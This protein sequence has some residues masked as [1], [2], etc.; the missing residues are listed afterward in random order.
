MK[1]GIAA[2]TAPNHSIRSQDERN[3]TMM[4]NPEVGFGVERELRVRRRRGSAVEEVVTVDRLGLEQ[5]GEC[6]RRL[7]GVRQ[8]HG[9]VSSEH[10]DLAV[11][12]P[13]GGDPQ[14]VGPLRFGVEVTHAPEWIGREDA[15]RQETGHRDDR[16]GTPKR[17]DEMRRNRSP[18]SARG[19]HHLHVFPSF[20]IARRAGHDGLDLAGGDPE[21]RHRGDWRSGTGTDDE[22]GIPTREAGVGLE[23]VENAGV[24]QPSAGTAA[25]ED[26]RN[27]H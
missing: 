19:T 27:A 6:R 26:E 13:Y 17:P 8:G 23:R 21:S 9:V 11:V 5:E 18:R 7:D 4:M 20:C 10:D 14:P 24:K 2:A 25:P 12:R 3:S 1:G 16:P 15:R 22:A